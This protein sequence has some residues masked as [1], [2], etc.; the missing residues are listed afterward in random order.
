MIRTPEQ[1]IKSL[2]DG[3]VIFL[4]GEQIPDITKHPAMKGAIARR[5]LSYVLANDPE[6][7]DLFTVEEDGERRMF[8]WTQPKTAEDLVRRREIYMTAHRIGANMSG[9]GPDALAATGV[10]A[11]RMDKELGTHYTDALEDYRRHLKKKPIR[12][13]PGRSPMSKETEVFG[14]R[15]R[16]NIRTS[17]SG[18]WTGKKTASSSEGPRCTSVPPPM[19]MS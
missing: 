19:P 2:N 11:A 16:N 17:M 15:P 3:R 6:W 8:V 18:W 7:R 1:Y 5:A 12:P 10:V 13:L 9:M 4:D 14:R